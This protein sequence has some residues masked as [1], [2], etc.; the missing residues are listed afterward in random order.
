MIYYHL[1]TKFDAKFV[2]FKKLSSIQKWT[3][4]K[5]LKSTSAASND[6]KPQLAHTVGTRGIGGCIEDLQKVQY[7]VDVC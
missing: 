5:A 7:H 3:Q 4:L 1:E 2:A 6:G